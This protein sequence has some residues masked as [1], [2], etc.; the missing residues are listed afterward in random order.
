M[1]PLSAPDTAPAGRAVGFVVKGY[2][3]LSETFIAQEIR[4]LEALGLDIRIISLRHPTDAKRHPIHEEIAASVLYL[5]E[6]LW[7]EPIRVLAGWRWSR[8]L[9]GYRRA[10]AVSPRQCHPPSDGP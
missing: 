9:P 10:R 1:P 6:Y 4:A 5:P 8:G 2:P 7:R 3:R